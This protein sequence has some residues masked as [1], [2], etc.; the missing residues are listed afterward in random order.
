M[1]SCNDIFGLGANAELAAPDAEAGGDVVAGLTT[2]VATPRA[3][4]DTVGNPGDGPNLSPMGVPAQ[5]EVDT[6]LLSILQ[7][8]GL[9]V[10][11]NR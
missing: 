3:F 7:V 8:V 9:V 1:Q 6:S 11:D 2:L 4:V 10:K 5:L